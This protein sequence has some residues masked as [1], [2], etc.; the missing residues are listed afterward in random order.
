MSGAFQWAPVSHPV[1]VEV[2]LGEDFDCIET[3]L[4]GEAVNLAMRP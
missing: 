3:K 2:S 1:P 4:Y